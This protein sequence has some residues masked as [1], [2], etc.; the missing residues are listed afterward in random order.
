VTEDERNAFLR[1]EISEPV[2]AE[3]ALDADDEIATIRFDR[4]EE[5]LGL[6]AQVAV[7]DDL[8]ALVVEDSEIHG[9][10]VEID[11]AVVS[12]LACVETHGSPPGSDEWFALS[13]FLPMSGRSRRGL[14][15]DQGIAAARVARSVSLR[16]S[17]ARKQRSTGLAS[18]PVRL[19]G[20]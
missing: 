17:T 14:Y 9:P 5:A 3:D 18:A 7:Q 12:M 13:S 20:R 6:A 1:A 8:A 2:P 10:G 11:P 19:R 4:P 16:P 15:H